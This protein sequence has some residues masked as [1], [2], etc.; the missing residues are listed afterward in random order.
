[1]SAA[2]K[3]QKSYSSRLYWTPSRAK[4]A[5]Q[6]GRPFL[7]RMGNRQRI[8]HR[9]PY[10]RLRRREKAQESW[11]VGSNQKGRERK[12]SQGQASSV[13]RSPSCYSLFF[14]PFGTSTSAYR[15]EYRTCFQCGIAGHVHTSC[16]FLR[17]LWQ[18]RSAVW[19]AHLIETGKYG[20]SLCDNQRRTHR[21]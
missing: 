11:K 14:R 18:V 20:S 3:T 8:R 7:S 15:S 16:P 10:R 9:R 19:T 21:G 5:H 13:P 12:E 1:M 4:K 17:A 2:L 6:A